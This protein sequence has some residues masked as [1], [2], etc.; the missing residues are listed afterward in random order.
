MDQV[1]EARARSDDGSVDK[2]EE[3]WDEETEETVDDIIG[4]AVSF[5]LTQSLRLLIG[6]S[7]PNAEGEEP[8]EGLSK[9]TD[10]QAF[11]LLFIS[12]VFVAIEL[13]R[14]VYI[15]RT[16][17]RF[18][19]QMRNVVMMTLSWCLFFSCD[20][21]LS[22]NFFTQNHGMTKEVVLALM[23]TA[24][25]MSMI[26][27]LD[28]LADLPITGTAVD[29]AIRSV[30][31]AYGIL[32][33][34]SWEKSFDTAVAEVSDN[35]KF[36]PEHLTKMLLAVLLVVLVVPAWRLYIL[37]TI[38]RYEQLE[39]KEEEEEAEGEAR[40][41][42]A[43]EG[44]GLQAPLLRSS[45]SKLSREKLKPLSGPEAA[46]LQRKCRAYEEKVRGLEERNLSLE[47]SLKSFVVELNEL[48]QMA[49]MLKHE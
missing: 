46:E 12:L 5:L 15:K 10:F 13:L 43:E 4:L 30:V 27:L 37:P 36:V 22:H 24:I 32:I 18:T 41:K 2:F 19:P 20:W 45:T 35:V 39:E 31:R 26:F 38:L 11:Q 21:W 34:F 40:E 48:Q 8:E 42:E 7:L 23:V 33:G 25:A 28:K 9:H 49:E 47:A 29:K 1:R 14:L 17:V 6:G 16:F 3:L 44:R